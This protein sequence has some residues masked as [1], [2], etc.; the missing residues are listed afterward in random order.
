[1]FSTFYTKS[2]EELNRIYDRPLA[3]I[4]SK[5]AYDHFVDYTTEKH[6]MAILADKEVKRLEEIKKATYEM[7]KTWDNTIENIN[8]KKE[9][10]LL[11]K[12]KKEEADNIQFMEE[13]AA[14]KAAEHA[15]VIEEARKLLLYT[16]PQCRLINRA[17]LTSECLRE[18]DAQL[19]FQRNLKHLEKEQEN[20]SS[21]NFKQEIKKHEEEE[22]KRAEEMILK[23]K[24]YASELKKQ[25]YRNECISRKKEVLQKETAKQELTNITKKI[26]MEKKLETEESEKKKKQ[27]REQF[28]KA[29]ED[30]RKHELKVK[31]DQE[32]EEQAM[33]VYNKG[34]RQ[35]EAKLDDQI[36]RE[37]EDRIRRSEYLAK[38]C[39]VIAKS[40]DKEEETILK[41]ALEKK[42]AEDEE[43][44]IIRKRYEEKLRMEM[45]KYRQELAVLVENQKKEEEQFKV[46][47]IKQRLERDKFNKDIK[48]QDYKREK[49][50]KEKIA[51]T[52]RRQIAQKEAE[53]KRIKEL[54]DKNDVTKEIIE[55]TNEK[56]LSYGEE[57]LKESEG[58]RPLYPIVKVLQVNN[59]KT[60]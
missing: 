19:Q 37:K 57:V 54:D 35:I 60:K 30:K 28:L 58:V 44:K 1:M 45:E 16:K 31:R 9:E 59:L 51:N 10:E 29:L 24:I 27:L 41:K 20:E 56:I 5:K 50:K 43:K 36:K 32:F 8:R 55:K 34:K 15:E 4:A 47:E 49:L 7:S 13:M 12:T 52:L 26:E 2:G 22:R 42:N 33:A 25:I 53:Q 6:R 23:N 21:E 17:L 40:R 3:L 48:I 11:A 38:K 39:A 18:L 14:K 46:W